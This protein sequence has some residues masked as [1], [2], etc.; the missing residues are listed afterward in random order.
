MSSL[1]DPLLMQSNW[2]NMGPS[3]RNALVGRSNSE[4]WYLF[5]NIG[6]PI[7]IVVGLLLILRYR[8]KQKEIER[9]A[10]LFA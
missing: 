3:G 10:A 8:M 5:I 1:F 2:V 4:L 6:I 7:I 9:D